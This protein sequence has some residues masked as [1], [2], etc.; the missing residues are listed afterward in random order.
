[1]NS[2]ESSKYWVIIP[3]AGDGQRMQAD[4]PKQYLKLNDKTVLEHTLAVFDRP[5]L[6]S[7][8]VVV[9]ADS[10]PYWPQLQQSLSHFS[11]P[12]YT[13]VGGKER[14][15]SVLNAMQE[16]EQ[17]A[18]AKDWVLVHDA[19]RPCVT[20]EDITKLVSTLENETVGGLLASPVKDTIKR[21]DNSGRVSAT[22]ER[23]QL[24][25]ALTP[26]MFRF[27]ILYKALLQALTSKEIA[28]YITDDASAVEQLGQKPLLVEGSGDNIK[29]TTPEDMLVAEIYLSQKN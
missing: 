2:Q 21:S 20:W 5:E 24:W 23:N 16:L 22:V 10:D 25:R 26:Q 7:A 4:C 28:G 27:E 8:I 15:D 9:L 17:Y 12:L 29:I 1:M 11:V 6:I 19:A 18:S 13:T 14:C 3:A